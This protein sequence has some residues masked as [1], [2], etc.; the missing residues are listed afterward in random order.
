MNFSFFPLLF[1]PSPYLF[2]LFSFC[3]IFN[4][5]FPFVDWF[6]CFLL[7]HSSSG[8]CFTPHMVAQLLLWLFC[9]SH[10]C[11]FI[12][13]I[14][15]ISPHGFGW[16]FLSLLGFFHIFCSSSNDFVWFSS[17]LLGSSRVYSTFPIFCLAPFMVLFVPLVGLF[18]SSHGCLVLLIAIMLLLCLLP[19]LWLSF[20]IYFVPSNVSSSS[21][22]IFCFMLTKFKH[23][24]KFN[25]H[26]YLAPIVFVF[27]TLFL[28]V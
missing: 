16:L 26:V 17:W 13:M 2:F 21:S 11:S 1:T 3:P 24:L 7:F 18:N 6:F 23:L 25:S 5:F 8:G 27:L 20:W 10:V 12:L 9:S 22:L 14:I 15:F 28:W 4:F 19:T